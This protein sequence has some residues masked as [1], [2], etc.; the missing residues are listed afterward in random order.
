MPRDVSPFMRMTCSGFNDPFAGCYSHDVLPLKA[1]ESVQVIAEHGHIS[2]IPKSCATSRHG[3]PADAP[4][5]AA[6]SRERDMSCNRNATSDVAA[7]TR[8]PSQAPKDQ[9]ML[10]CNSG[11]STHSTYGSCLGSAQSPPA[12]V[13]EAAADVTSRP[14]QLLPAQLKLTAAM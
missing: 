13:A 8:A 7:A 12:D 6:S 5:A 1:T 9:S 14:T 11:S 4:K 10:S 2:V 3:G